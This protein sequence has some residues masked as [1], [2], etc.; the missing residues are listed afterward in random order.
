MRVRPKDEWVSV[1]APELRIVP[2]ELWD[3]VH[4][5]QASNR[6]PHKEAVRYLTRRVNEILAQPRTP[7]RDA[8]NR[9]LEQARQ[10]LENIK[11]AIRQGLITATTKAMLEE[12]EARVARG[13]AAVREADLPDG[14]L[15]VLPKLIEHRLRDLQSVVGTKP[16]QSTG[17]PS[18]IDWRRDVAT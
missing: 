17:D 18:K 1:A 2:D 4:Q 16:D 8:A 3:R 12:T 7:R 6:R 5:Q 11:S 9:E 13:E 14:K 10:D 15:A